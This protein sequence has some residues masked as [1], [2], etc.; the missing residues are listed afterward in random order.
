MK[1]STIIF[2]FVVL[3]LIY[4]IQ[5]RNQIS[6]IIESFTQQTGEAN[7]LPPIVNV[8]DGINIPY[9]TVVGG[10]IIY[11][12][13]NGG[14]LIHQST[15]GNSYTNHFMFTPL[16]KTKQIVNNNNKDNLEQRT[17]VLS[18][19]CQFKDSDN[20]ESPSNTDAEVELWIFGLNKGR[21][22]YVDQSY[23]D[24]KSIIK[25]IPKNDTWTTLELKYQP[26]NLNTEYIAI[27]FDNNKDAGINP[28]TVRW[29]N[30]KLEVYNP[31]ASTQRTDCQ[32]ATPYAD[33]PQLYGTGS[34]D[35]GALVEASALAVNKF[36]HTNDSLRFGDLDNNKVTKNL[37]FQNG[38]SGNFH[39]V[40]SRINSYFPIIN[41]VENINSGQ[42]F[43]QYIKVNLKFV[44]ETN[45][46]INSTDHVMQIIKFLFKTFTYNL[47]LTTETFYK[48]NLFG[49]LKKQ[50][51][52]NDDRLNI[53]D[54]TI[55][56]D[57]VN[58]T[59]SKFSLGAF[60]FLCNNDTSI[61]NLIGKVINNDT[62][63]I[64]NFTNYVNHPVAAKHQIF[65]PLNIYINSPKSIDNNHSNL[66]SDIINFLKSSN[67]FS[68][69]FTSIEFKPFNGN[70]LSTDLS[71]NDFFEYTNLN[72]SNTETK[73]VINCTTYNGDRSQCTAM[74]TEVSGI[75]SQVQECSCTRCSD[76]VSVKKALVNSDHVIAGQ[77]DT[78]PVLLPGHG[79]P[80]YFCNRQKNTSCAS[81]DNNETVCNQ[82]DGCSYKNNFCV[83]TC[84][85]NF[86][87]NYFT[88]TVPP[89]NLSLESGGSMASNPYFF[90]DGVDYFYHTNLLTSQ[91][92]C[93]V[94]TPSQ[95]A[96][97]VETSNVNMN[98]FRNC[99]LRLDSENIPIDLSLCFYPYLNNNPAQKLYYSVY[100]GKEF[101]WYRNGSAEP[102]ILT[103]SY[104]TGNSIYYFLNISQNRI[105]SFKNL[106]KNDVFA[107]NGTIGDYQFSLNTNEI[108]GSDFDV[109]NGTF[110]INNGS[111]TNLQEQNY[112]LL[113]P[114]NEVYN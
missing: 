94:Y 68:T 37:A 41:N 90:K 88:P 53:T 38:N 79:N 23:Q 19:E 10:S 11:S 3:F 95:T 8:D 91:N 21:R 108:S 44:L 35:D 102:E 42:H 9:S 113:I 71:G 78:S 105:N 81:H 14:C 70:S 45:T 64:Y 30:P 49:Y 97:N 55:A 73:P 57:V 2:L 82:T 28:Q 52:N 74:A 22:H 62:T 107:D 40:H 85:F 39:L 25:S 29:K 51:Y 6:E 106:K 72:R 33:G 63:V 43:E 89:F 27:R 48:N 75:G 47:S 101:F 76:N 59:K 54:I 50:Y 100:R 83:P 58:T 80:F 26:L 103:Y 13:D 112:N 5:H 15:L 16:H 20:I 46:V 84:E 61:T 7:L 66:K 114:I 36:C 87:P 92:S 96:I 34:G 1:S 32:Y 60:F 18:V 111:K 86:P 104:S 110:K 31:T 67:T 56:N 4:C 99:N 109:S 98:H 12:S 65:L 69:G 77:Q 93:Q 24:F 17:Y